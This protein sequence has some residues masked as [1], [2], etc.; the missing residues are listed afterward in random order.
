MGTDIRPTS[1]D[2]VALWV[3]ER[4]AVAGFYCEY[5][6]MH[7][8]EKTDTFTLVGV[9]AKLGKLTLFD[10]EGPR[11][12]GSL[13]R[14]APRVRNLDAAAWAPPQMAALRGEDGCAELNAP[15][16]LPIVL[17]ER[18]GA[19]FDLDHVVLRLPERES[20]LS[21]LQRMGFDRW[22]GGLAVGNRGLRIV[23]GGEPE[24][25]RPLLDHIALLV[26]SAAEVQPAPSGAASRSTT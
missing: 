15:G 6:G 9:D 22:D 11:E 1:L 16:G 7:V 23:G 20:A 19:D 5:L 17:V 8:I 4:D 25:E 3:D 26:E 12:R 10:A 18:D 24:A 14:I 13:E 21:E 2:H